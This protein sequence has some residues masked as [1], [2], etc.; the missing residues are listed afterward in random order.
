VTLTLPPELSE[1][2]LP[3][4]GTQVPPLAPE[5]RGVLLVMIDGHLGNFVI[6]LPVIAAL[7]DYF[8]AAPE[9]IVDA[10]YAP[11]IRRLPGVGRVRVYPEQGRRRRGLVRNVAP[12]AAMVGAGLRRYRAVIDFGGGQRTA[13][14]TAATLA[15]RRFGLAMNRRSGLY[16][17]PVK[18]QGLLHAYHRYAA[19]LA[20]IGRRTLPPLVRLRPRAAVVE[21]VEAYLASLLPEPGAPLV[22]IHAGASKA[23]RQWPTERFAQ[24][25]DRLVERRGVNIGLIGAPAERP[26]MEALREAMVRRDAACVLSLPLESLLALYERAALL[27]SNES[28]PTHLAAATELPIATVFGPTEES[29]WRPLRDER[30]IILRGAAC[31]P[32]CAR[33]HCAAGN[34]CLTSLECGAVLEAAERLLAAPRAREAVSA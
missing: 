18:A 13:Y 32:A 22:L 19:L 34:R 29:K 9:V 14:Y 24:V 8:H 16:S 6:S 2:A 15:R 1:I 25:A 11:L 17:H 30:T 20:C 3:A 12:L 5:A 27:L 33:E 7:L 26:V 4:P 23:W 10:R 28:G 21:E 31:D